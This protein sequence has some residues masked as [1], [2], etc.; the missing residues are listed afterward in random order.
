MS[1]TSELLNCGLLSEA[2]G[3]NNETRSLLASD[4]FSE[5]IKYTEDT[6]MLQQG[7]ESDSIYFTISGLF[8]AVSHANEQTPQ[9]LLGRIEPGEFIAE[10]S[11]FDSTT[12]ACASVKAMKNAI[13]LK[14]SRD[15]Y[16]AL[17]ESHSMQALQFTCAVATGLARRLRYA[18]EKVM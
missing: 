3:V 1:E 15:N 12:H 7:Q 11:F 9:R 2:A 4:S 18:N 14:I 17:C 5:I 10:I 13:V 8:H 16:K 6:L